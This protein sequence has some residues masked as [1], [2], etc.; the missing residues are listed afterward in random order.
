MAHRPRTPAHLGKI[1][2]WVTLVREVRAGTD[3]T[4]LCFW[5]HRP[6]RDGRMGASCPSQWWPAPFTV[7]AVTCP[8]AE[9][10]TTAGTARPFGDAGTERRMP[11]ARHPGQATARGRLV[12]RSDEETWA[13][14][15]RASAVEG[16]VHELAAHPELRGFAPGTGD[17]VPLEAGPLDRVWGVGP[18][19]DDAAA[20]DPERWKGLNLLG[21]A[22]MEARER[23]RAGDVASGARRGPGERRPGRQVRGRAARWVRPAGCRRTGGRRG[24]RRW[25]RRH[26]RRSET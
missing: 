10:R 19:A 9:H 3:I 15:R 12:R 22:L 23:L 18:A 5:G 14:E 17:T 8:T 4:Y 2:P 7:D 13:R 26:P 25:P 11:A 20:T 24:C 21:F 6:R 16:G 1:D